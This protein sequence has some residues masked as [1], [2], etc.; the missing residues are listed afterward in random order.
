MI[1]RSIRVEGWRCFA[2]AVEVG[3]FGDGLNV[4]HGPNGIGKS[5]L[6]MALVR[7]LFDSHAVGG[8]D[9]KALRPWGRSLNP[10][11]TIEFEQNGT[12]YRLQK[13]FV[14]STSAA[15]SRLEDGRFVP[16]AEGR[17]ADDQAREILSAEPPSRGVSDQRH[18]GLA[19]ILW[20]TQGNM[21]IDQISSTTRTT[22]QDALGAQVAGPGAETLERKIA[23]AY[24]Q[25]FTPTGKLKGGAAAPAV[26]S[27]REQ[28][29]AA[30]TKRIE[31]TQRMDEFDTASRR[32]EDL[33]NKT[34]QA[35]YTEQELGERLKIAREQ[36]QQFSKL[37]TQRKLHEQE[38]TAAAERYKTLKKQIDEIAATRQELQSALDQ[39][40]RLQDDAPAAAKQVTQCRADAERM[41]LAV[42]AVR[43]R[44]G[45]IQIAR[46]TAQT[47]ERFTNA[48]SDLIKL[49]ELLGQLDEAQQQRDRLHA[50]REKLVAPDSKTLQKI[51]QTARARDDARLR[52]DAAVIT[53]RITAESDTHLDVTAAENPGRQSLPADQT[54][55]IKGAPDV[56]F[57]IPGV[58]RFEATGPTKDASDLR[59][60]WETAVERLDELTTG[61][62]TQNIERLELLH[63]EAAELDTQISQVNVRIE[64]LRGGRPLEEIRSARAK[65]LS[66]HEEILAK[67]P[68]W[69]NSP[70]DAGVLARQTDELRMKFEADIDQA[71]AENDR[72]RDALNLA[73]QQQTGH[74]AKLNSAA[75]QIAAVEKRL[76]KLCD[77]DLDDQQRSR[78]LTEIALQ[79]DAAQGKLNQIDEQLK[80]FGDDPEKLTAALEAQLAAV[81]QDAADA[82][83]QLN[84]EEGRLQQIAAEAPYSALAAVE[85]AINRLEEE[86]A[87]QDLQ[88]SA[89][90]LLYETLTEHK[91]DLLHAIIA[92]VR[93]RANQTLQRITGTRFND[94]HFD[95]SLLPTGV[96]PRSTDEPV[97]LTEISGGEREQLY[98][99]VRLA[100]ADVAFGAERQLVVLDDVFTYTDTTRLAR[101]ATILAEAAGR[102]QIVLLACHPER[103]RGLADATF[104]DLE[105]ISA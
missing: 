91:R 75:T 101:I 59:R 79:Q 88:I 27:L 53:V 28:L 20:A 56:A 13:Q 52:L 98:F 83:R 43:A 11:V 36:D 24:G 15:L 48:C 54:L 63:A 93:Q 71:E 12:S 85:E 37:S 74:E 2:A 89:V 103:Y 29:D 1:L 49:D 90:R 94:I 8:A 47:A 44:R 16:L 23:D 86:I 41:K 57:H 69:Q 17:A 77:D 10:K 73:V 46:Q 102:F 99:A 39:H 72:A 42:E 92:P 61:F 25:F 34:D 50:Q 33:R 100:L 6:M 35:K 62:G 30:K 80:A 18:W 22:I 81:R 45:E 55:A 4:V 70:P 66:V 95:E 21:Q 26:V 82:A 31:L 97:A 65:A 96:A 76:A 9:V 51:K 5:T 14:S 60:Q 105:A 87:A 7:G 78:R 68:D 104:F 58:A 40:R 84:T 38:S 67:F 3:P 64:T 19:Q 32:I